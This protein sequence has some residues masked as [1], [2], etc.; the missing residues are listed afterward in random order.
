MSPSADLRRATPAD[1]P[2]L[3]ALHL[4]VWRETYRDLAPA[5][6][7]ARLDLPHRLRGWEAA[8]ARP[9]QAAWLAE[10][11]GQAL[12]LVAAAP[13]SDP[14]RAVIEGPAGEIRH[15]YVAPAARRQGLGQRLLDAAFA[16]LAAQGCT[17]AALG[18]VQQNTAARRFYA[19]AGGREV[20][21]FTDP[22]PLWR[23]AMILVAWDLPAPDLSAPR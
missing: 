7:F 20:A 18:V 12:G 15:L 23:S 21:A 19:S 1:A 6:A 13:P 17:T 5:A 9:E 4:S 10:A 22:G 16:A 11:G 8:L 2:A 14:V 3:A